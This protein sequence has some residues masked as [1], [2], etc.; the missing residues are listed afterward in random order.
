[1]RINI[2]TGGSRGDI[3]PFV[4]LALGLK[5][6]GHDPVITTQSNFEEWITG[7]GIDYRPMEGN[8]REMLESEDGI[9]LMESKGLDTFKRLRDLVEP[10]MRQSIKGL[11]ASVPGSELMIGTFGTY[12]PVMSLS[13]K[14]GIPW[15]MAYLQPFHPTRAFPNYMALGKQMPGLINY[16][17]HII[18]EQAQWIALRGIGNTIRREMFDMKPYPLLGAMHHARKQHIPTLYA[19]SPTVMPKPYDWGEHIDVTGYWFLDEPGWSPPA[20][21]VHFLNSGPAPVYI[22]LGS[23]VTRTPEKFAEIALKALE[24][25]GQRGILLTGWGGIKASDLPTSVMKID[26]APHGWLFPQ[27]AAV[28]H[29]GGAGTT[30]SGLRAGVP[31]IVTPLFADQPYWGSR[32][33]EMGVGPAPIMLRDLTVEKLA[34]AITTTLNNSDMKHRA[35]ALGEKIRTEDGVGRAVE[36]ISRVPGQRR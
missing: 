34:D 5:A 12:A 28:V 14:Y 27:M 30:A 16:A 29:H 35:A 36:F 8:V 19:I 17:T 32:V 13:E 6:A 31:S 33:V 4:P 20:D 18:A 9:K 10:V 15:M 22:G 2:I 26:G 11:L 25:T 24:M 1:M 3:Q 23:M 7:L 21:L